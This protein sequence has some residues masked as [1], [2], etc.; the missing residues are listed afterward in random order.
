MFFIQNTLSQFFSFRSQS[1]KFSIMRKI[2]FIIFL[3]LVTSCTQNTIP[4]QAPKDTS[5]V[6]A[7]YYEA[8]AKRQL[9]LECDSSLALLYLEKAFSLC[10]SYDPQVWFY[11]AEISFDKG[12]TN[13]AFDYLYEASLRGNGYWYPYGNLLIY[14]NQD[15][16]LL[17]SFVSISDSVNLMFSKNFA[18]FDSILKIDQ[19]IRLKENGYSNEVFKVD[20]AI[21]RLLVNYIIE[22][23]FPK[24]SE[25]SHERLHHFFTI[26]FRHQLS[27][28]DEIT[29]NTNFKMINEAMLVAIHAG[30]LEPDVYAWMYDE[31]SWSIDSMT[32]FG[33]LKGAIPQ[34]KVNLEGIDDRRRS[35]GLLPIHF[36]VS[37][38]EDHEAGFEWYREA[39]LKG[40]TSSL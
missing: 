3:A 26:V 4:G 19:D 24:S 35:I 5:C 15:S 14:V 40:V 22:N 10:Q 17:Q 33:V 13:R 36:H 25:L 34:V 39:F 20:T 8:L 23:G 29:S 28:G 21:N 2:S 30:E 6:D 16:S 18:F 37:Y 12:D 1:I 11:A 9:Q 32:H 38:W 7:R 27:G 31:R